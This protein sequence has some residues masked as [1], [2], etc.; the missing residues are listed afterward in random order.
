MVLIRFNVRGSVRF[1]SHA[2]TVRVFQRA[3]VR[4]GIEIR[5]SQG[6]N[7]HPK[8]SLPLPRPVGVESDGDLLCI[9]I[10]CSPDE[11]RA[12]NYVSRI[13]AALSRQLPQG[14]ELL[15]VEVTEA[16]SAPQPRL[17]E[18]VLNVQ[19]KYLNEDL[20]SRIKN[21][22]EHKRLDISR[23]IDASKLK[24]ETCLTTVKNQKSEIKSIDVRP[25]LKSIALD[26]R[27]IV[28]ECGISSAGSIRVQEIL[29][30]LQLD[31]D[32]LAAPIRRTNI[33]WQEN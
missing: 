17:A 19:S 16:K 21:L 15:S 7:P 27:G 30:L 32:K 33:Q 11:T 9:Q 10:D 5:Y 2:E 3:C 22:L 8:L 25:F 6:F 12:A 24:I 29:E 13:K 18:Y 20:Q 23:L 1:L 14:V 31:V 26:N 4:A 28:V